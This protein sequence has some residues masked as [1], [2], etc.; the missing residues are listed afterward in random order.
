MHLFF[1]SVRMNGRLGRI[2]RLIGYSALEYEKPA[3]GFVLGG[4]VIRGA[5]EKGWVVF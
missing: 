4:Q 5:V 2:G 1:V 3:F